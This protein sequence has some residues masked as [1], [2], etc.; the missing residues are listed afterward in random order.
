MDLT[1]C[2]IT[3]EC[4]GRV[5]ATQVARAAALES[6]VKCNRLGLQIN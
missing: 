4:N 3:L 5:I 2:G 6:P 1:T